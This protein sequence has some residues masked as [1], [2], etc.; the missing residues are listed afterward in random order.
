MEKVKV[1]ISVRNLVEFVLRSGDI[2]N[3]RGRAAQKEAMQEGS[4]IHRKIQRRMGASYHAEVPLKWEIEYENYDLVVEGRA[5]GIMIEPEKVTVDEIK[6]IYQDVNS[7]TEAIPVHLAQAKCYAYIYGMQA[8]LSEI[9]VQM[10]YCNLDT[11]EIR[12]FQESFHMDMLAVWFEELIEAYRK[13]ADFQ[14]TARQE[15]QESIQNLEFPF[16]YREGQ[17]EL[18]AGVYRTICRE[19][20]LFIQAPTGTGKTISVIFPAVRGVGEGHGDKIFYLTAKTITRTVAKEAFDLLRSRGYHGS[21]LTI[22]AKEKL[23][24]C[25]EMECNPVACPYAKGHY[26]RVND[27]VFDLINREKDVTREVLLAQA[28]AYLVCPFELCLDTSLW[29][30]NIICDYNYVFDPNVYLKRFFSEGIKGDYIFLIDEAHNLVERGRQMYSASLYKEEF[31]EVKKLLKPYSV[32]IVRN[33]EKCNKF[34]LEMKR[35]CENWQV[36]DNIG[37][38]IFALMNLGA[39]MDEF[40]QKNTEFPE[41]KRVLEFYLLLRHFLNMYERLD[42][43][44]VIY[45]Q[46]E[47]DG[48]FF[49]KLYCVNPSVNLQD[50]LNRGRSAVFFSA[51]LLPIQYYKGL[52][53]TLED[54]YAV[55][56]KSVFLREQSL[57]LVAEDVSSKYT[58]RNQEEFRRIAGYIQET[59]RAKRGNYM[60]FF[61]SYKLLEQVLAVCREYEE[62]D[63]EYLVQAPGMQEGEREEFL[64]AFSQ[65]RK[66][67]LVGFCVMGGI[68]AEGIDLREEQLI[69]AIVVGTGLP[70]INNEREILRQYYDERENGGFDHAYR[71]PGMNKVMQ[72]AGRVI[73]T[74][75]DRG[76]ILLL[77]ERFLQYDYRRL[78]PREWEGFRICSREN[79]AE[80]L[81]KFWEVEIF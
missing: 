67:A 69:G 3:R 29:M 68:F 55:Y 79:V 22:T 18:V 77:D 65:K 70:Q 46:H 17:K 30:D 16:P 51:T 61:P 58:R 28:E 47:E 44:Y 64:A 34:L 19:K 74:V 31:L 6:G 39:S 4:R 50:C 71:Y 56:A 5:D 36:L 76:V 48:R 9:K 38:L 25:E 37:H 80:M 45:T 81:K 35:E 57:I 26:D 8:A 24:L 42:E 14:F 21:V 20:N 53:S 78:F 15:R 40:F 32:K 7:L 11:E 63:V 49:L 73:R 62:M 72:A 41:K 54:N 27:A 33:L 52:L 10:T 13:W 43:N 1:K 75:A 2:D 23:C 60:V 12:Y 59:V 66:Q